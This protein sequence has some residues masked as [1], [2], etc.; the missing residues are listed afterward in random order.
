[1]G[2]RTCEAVLSYEIAKVIMFE[3]DQMQ[4]KLENE[5]ITKGQT[6]LAKCMY[7][8]HVQ[9]T[10]YAQM[11]TKKIKLDGTVYQLELR[12]EAQKLK[13]THLPMIEQQVDCH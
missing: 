12:K 5:L 8:Q 6:K 9:K 4:T 2:I 13:L 11:I 10:P 7:D 1:M 3:Q